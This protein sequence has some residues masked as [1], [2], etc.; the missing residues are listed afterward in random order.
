[1]LMVG[2]FWDII[3]IKM[4]YITTK[5]ATITT[6][7]NTEVSYRKYRNKYWLDFNFLY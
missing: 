3:V 6:T 5:C 4:Y 1:M 2:Q 7:S